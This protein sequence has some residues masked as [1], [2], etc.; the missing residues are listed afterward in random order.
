MAMGADVLSLLKEQGQQFLEPDEH[1]I[2]A[3]QAKPRGSGVA[4]GGGGGLGAQAVGSVWA[5][6]SRDMAAGAGLQVTSPMVLALTDRRV[7]VFGGDTSMGTGKFTGI[8]EMVSS[9]PLGDV[10]SIRIKR[11]LIGKTVTVALRGGEVKLEVP[12][13]QDA[14][15]FVQEFERITS[16]T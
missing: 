2:A 7:A 5:R 14:K 13:G 8:T 10:E 12:P 16:A 6:K 4:T 9:V 11:L 15:G 1:V 3:F